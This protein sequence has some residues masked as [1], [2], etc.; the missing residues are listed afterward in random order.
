MQHDERGTE[1]HPRARGRVLG[2]DVARALAV[3]GMVMVHVGPGAPAE[4]APLGEQLYALSRG[5]AS[6]LFVVLAGIG[7][8]LLAGD[9]S[10]DRL[11]R[12]WVRVVWRAA[13]LL[14]LGLALQLLDH[15]VAVILQ[16]YALYFLL[17]GVSA[18]LGGRA[19]LLVSA[20]IYAAGPLVYL[21]AWHLQPEWFT[22]GPTSL[23][24]PPAVWPRQLLLTG[25]Y[26]AIV[27]SAPLLVGVWLGR[28]PLQS[29]RLQRRMAGWGFAGALVAWM[30]SI[31]LVALVGEPQAE[32]SWRM[33]ALD[34]PHSAMPLWLLGATGAAIGLLGLCLLVARVLPST[35]WPLAATG[36]LAFTLYVG[37]LLVLV[38]WPDLLRYDEVGAATMSVIR[39]TAVAVAVSAA[40]LL[41][42]PRGPLELA[43]RPPWTWRRG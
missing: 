43:L 35:T 12:M 39:F 42:L 14:P 6:V 5:R 32:P 37:H 26:P 30:T 38:G 10:R 9:R 24:H 36:Q 17:A 41:V 28:Q 23:D 20:V 11:R 3:I 18:H 31:G 33:L 13:V 16:Y 25:W 4:G 19:V 40:W 21:G 34:T 29:P 7:V 1:G 8:T 22:L 27:W 15:G 2:I